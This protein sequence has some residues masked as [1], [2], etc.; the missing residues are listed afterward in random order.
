MRERVESGEQRSCK[1]SEEPLSGYC[2]KDLLYRI[3]D[4]HKD[5]TVMVT[6]HI[7]VTELVM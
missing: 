7:F 5:N 4:F 6:S 1:R 2:L 3:L